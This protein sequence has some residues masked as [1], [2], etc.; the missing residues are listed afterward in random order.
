MSKERYSHPQY[1]KEE[2]FKKAV[3]ISLIGVTIFMADIIS[4][5]PCSK[6]KF[7]TMFPPDS[8]E[9]DTLK[10]NID[11]NKVKL[12]ANI[13]KKWFE[14]GDF[15]GQIALY[16]LCSDEEE[17]AKLSMSKIDIT[18]AGERIQ[19]PPIELKVYDGTEQTT[20]GDI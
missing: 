14:K 9:F 1:K 15:N 6:Q 3:E 7:Y 12:K 18:S 19:L 5:L 2:V 17:L 13:R 4:Q 16:K 8:D 10:G 11:N 20:S